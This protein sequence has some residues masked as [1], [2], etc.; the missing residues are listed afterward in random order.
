MYKASQHVTA[1]TELLGNY[2]KAYSAVSKLRSNPASSVY[3]CKELF[4]KK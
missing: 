3:L 1:S 2:F 4:A